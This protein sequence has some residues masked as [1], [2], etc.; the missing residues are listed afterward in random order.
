[1]NTIIDALKGMQDYIGSNGRTDVDIGYAEDN[2]QLFF[3]KD[4]QEYLGQIGLA[5]FDG[6][7]LTGITDDERLDVISVTKEKRALFANIPLSWYVIEEA[8][9]DG[10][11]IWQNAEG[12]IYQTSPGCKPSKIAN[13]LLEYILL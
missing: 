1:M 12:E 6:H 13:S 8:N 4:Y 5:C 11:V 7:E 9:I 10:I 2:L 3:S